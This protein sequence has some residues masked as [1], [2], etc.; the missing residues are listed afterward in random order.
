MS[1]NRHTDQVFTE[2]K[3]PK[4]P[5]KFQIQ[6]NEEQKEAKQTILDSTVTILKGAA[7]SGK[8][9]LAAQVGLDLLFRKEVEK[10]I[11]TR[12]MVTPNDELELGI[13]PGGLNEKLSGYTAP[14][15]DNMF[16][17]YSKE[18][19]EFLIAEGKIE[20][21]PMSMLRG[22]NFTNCIVVGDEMQNCTDRALEMILTRI[23]RGTK[24]ILCGDSQ[25]IDL[26]K[27]SDSGFEVLCKN[28][29]DI[30]GFVTITLKTNHRHPIV[31]DILKMYSD[32][33][34]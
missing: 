25:Q 31:E 13:L 33:R 8:S 10:I 4:G 19:I 30:P 22:R 18:K 15:Y 29:K 6:L 16:R 9:L 28:S 5:I 32:I 24:V 2:K 21:I 20:V 34:S 7:G 1:S 27:K 11:I 14:V 17:L 12:P 3:V 26:K 23:C